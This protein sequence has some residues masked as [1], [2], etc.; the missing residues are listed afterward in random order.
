MLISRASGIEST[1][2]GT[3]VSKDRKSTFSEM[4]SRPEYRAELDLRK[5]PVAELKILERYHEQELVPCGMPGRHP[6]KRGCFVQAPDD[7]I[8]NIG[9]QC[10]RTHRGEEW[11]LV[12]RKFREREKD[13]ITFGTVEAFLAH[14]H[15]H[16]ERLKVLWDGER[17]G[18]WLKR[19][20]RLL[21]RLPVW[22][23][24]REMLR[25]GNG[26]I[27]DQSSATEDD[28]E[29]ARLGYGRGRVVQKVAGEITALDGGRSVVLTRV[30]ADLVE[31]L[32][33]YATFPS[34]EEMRHAERRACAR[35]CGSLEQ[36]FQRAERVIRDGQR[37][38]TEGNFR[39]IAKI[40][41]S[42]AKAVM[43]VWKEIE[44]VPAAPSRGRNS[45]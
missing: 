25:S 31:P 36:E 1:E 45:T 12:D 14:A 38:F 5:Y 17:G 44:S 43:T 35:F 41:P 27:Y 34:V 39:E 28:W 24:L 26:R 32:K 20:Q 22:D 37:F 13:A 16:M 11:N 3:R 21:E 29:L 2:R 23:E 7:L 18:W 40:S 10:A 33:R 4:C 9:R 19:C 8:T 30:Q 42:Y 6:H 15:A